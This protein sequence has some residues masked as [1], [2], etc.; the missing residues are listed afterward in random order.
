MSVPF[1]EQF[2]P[3]SIEEMVGQ[4][5]LF[6]KNLIFYKIISKNNIPN[7]IFYGPP[8]VGKTTV[9]NIIATNTEMLLCKLN[10]TTA[11]LD[12]V[13]KVIDDSKSVFASK[14]VLLYLDEIQYFNKKQQQSLLEYVEKG[15]ITLI[16]STTENPY[17]Y[18]Y[19]ALLSRCTVFEFKL[20][21]KDEIKKGLKRIINLKKIKIEDDAVDRLALAANGDIRKAINN[22][23]VVYTALGN[24]LIKLKDVDEI[25]DKAHIVYDKS[26]DKHF[27]HLS[28]L[29]KSLRGSDPDAAIFYLAKMLEAGDLQAVCR[30]IL[31]SVNEDVGLAYPGLIPIV[32]SCVDI[33]LQIGMPEAKLPLSNAVIL[34]AT[35]PKSNSSYMAYAKAISDIQMGKGSTVPRE[36][37]NTHFDGEDQVNK[38]QNYKYPHDYKNHYVKQQYLPDDVKDAH[39]YNYGNNKFEQALKEYWEKIK[40]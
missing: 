38:G 31:C 30:R 37:Q 3:K 11:S 13:K 16:A 10:G 18:I 25:V 8:G 33:A 12:D 21:S 19:P 23:E 35:A 24:K 36:L 34:I 7:M 28:A 9:A 15:L 39:Y 17:F 2:R 20:I 40:K 29:M 22:L 32:K 1:A 14:G 6:S 27:D 5:H 26:E 4:P